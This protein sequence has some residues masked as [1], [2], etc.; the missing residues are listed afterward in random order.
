M[1]P[2]PG[3]MLTVFLFGSWTVLKTVPYRHRLLASA[4]K[5]DDIFLSGER[6]GFTYT[7]GVGA[8]VAFTDALVVTGSGTS[9]VRIMMWV[10][11]T[12]RVGGIAMVWVPLST[13][14][15]VVAVGIA[16]SGQ[17]GV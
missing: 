5:S 2:S 9:L 7:R 1:Y 14:A 8:G 3:E 4:E 16:G 11:W 17:T 10:T 12:A 15:P 6:T 13:L